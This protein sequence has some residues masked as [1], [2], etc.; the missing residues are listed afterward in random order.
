M[1]LAD[2]HL[3]QKLQEKLSGSIDEMQAGIDKNLEEKIDGFIARLAKSDESSIELRLLV[4][5]AVR[6]PFRSHEDLQD[7]LVYEEA[8]QVIIQR[9]FWAINRL[10]AATWNRMADLPSL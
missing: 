9:R 2:I 3:H 7:N 10:R 8:K 6:T 1:V 5:E 4:L